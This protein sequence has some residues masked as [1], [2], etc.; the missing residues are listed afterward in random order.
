MIFDV[1]P[2]LSI[3]IA[4]ALYLRGCLRVR[5][6]VYPGRVAAFYGG[7]VAAALAL[8]GRVG[9]LSQVTFSGHMIQHVILMSASAP[10]VIA[11]DAGRVIRFGSPRS[12]VRLVARIPVGVRTAARAAAA[13]VLAYIVILWSWHLPTLYE[14]A[15]RN[16]AL[17][18]LEHL[19]F[20][21]VS[22]ILWA[23]AFGRRRASEPVALAAVFLTS[24]AG[25]ALGAVITFAGTVLYPVHAV[26]ATSIGLDA[27]VDQ[28]LAGA[29]MWVPPGVVSL[30]VM[31]LLVARM[32]SR[33]SSPAPVGSDR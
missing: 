10:L 33:A 5:G 23:L 28:Q 20:F 12:M 14:A 29:I 25:A 17:H 19:T 1:L 22:L 16:D 30:T 4:G 13:C 6:G 15:I 18:A 21:G 24:L 11:G 31:V 26:R 3:V 7:L 32:L 8:Y 2:A 9:D 27:L